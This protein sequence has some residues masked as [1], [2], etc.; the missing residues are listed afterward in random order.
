M[1]GGGRN[2]LGYHEDV[3]EYM[4][5]GTLV[6]SRDVNLYSYYKTHLEALG[7]K[8]VSVTALDKD[9]LNKLINELKPRLVLV[10]CDF[11]HCSTHFMMNRLLKLYPDLNI[12]A[13]SA[14]PYP[15]G[16]AAKFIANGVKSCVCWGD[17]PEQ[18]RNGLERVRDGKTFISRSVQERIEAMIEYPE[19]AGD[20]TER[21]T[22][23]IRMVCNGFT[24]EEIADT[25]DVSI[26]T[27]NNHKSKVYY[28]L[29]VRNENE[30]IRVAQD[31]GIIE[32]DELNFYGGGYGPGPDEKTTVRRI[33]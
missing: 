32:Q 19:P 21:H 20:L 3:R 22:E 15:A 12:V 8:N 29:S 17:G 23:V 26:S 13:V 11:Y 6:L 24:T 2:R 16:L 33:V 14:A 10:S 7:F 5:G 1:H 9:A 27:I 31:L 18:F 25:L 28:N 30:L 4:T